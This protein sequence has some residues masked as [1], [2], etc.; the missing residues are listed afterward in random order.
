[1]K[2]LFNFL[3]SKGQMGAL[4]LAV[5]CIVIVLGSIFGGLSSSNYDVGTDLV[6]ILKDKDS[7]ET[8][9]FF[10]SAITIPVIL[11]CIA[12]LLLVVF[13]IR[14]LVTD[15]KGSLKFIVSAAAVVVLFFIF[16]SMADAHVTGKAA[17][18]VAKDNLSDS[19]VKMIGGG[20]TT[21]V[22]LIGA[23]IVAAVVGGIINLFK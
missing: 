8:F 4:I 16:Q 9:D 12:A 1:M 7:T 20:I 15:P 10:N 18:L 22:L 21:T 19:T 11:I 6:Q 2:S 23:A 5:V 13:G 17:E 14:S 3:N